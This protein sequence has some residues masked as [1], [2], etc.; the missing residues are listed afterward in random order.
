M[1]HTSSELQIHLKEYK[2]VHTS[3]ELQ[4]HLVEYK[5]VHTSSELQIHLAYTPLSVSVVHY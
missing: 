4:I 5:S 1:V 2:S 3:S